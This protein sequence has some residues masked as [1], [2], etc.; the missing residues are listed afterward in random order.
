MGSNSVKGLYYMEIIYPTADGRSV[1]PQDKL[2]KEI[3]AGKIKKIVREEEDVDGD[4]DEYI[5]EVIGDI[6][7]GYDPKG[8]GMLPKKVLEKFFKDALDVY[9]MRQGRKKGSEVL[10]PGVKMGVAMKSAVAKV[11]QNPQGCTKQEFE[12]FIN[13][14]DLEEALGDFCG[15]TEVQVNTNVQMVDT[16]QFKEAQTANASKIVYRDYNQ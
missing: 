4:M 14:Y 8:T 10:S 12:N 15:T 1:V 5:D 7:A 2:E 16:T 6:F 11:T 9:A 3:A 13:C